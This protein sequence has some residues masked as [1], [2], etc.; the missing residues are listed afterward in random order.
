MSYIKCPKSFMSRKKMPF[1]CP[2]PCPFQI[3][4]GTLAGNL[5]SS[6]TSGQLPETTVH[7]STGHAIGEGL[8]TATNLLF[9]Q[10]STDAAPQTEQ[11]VS[12]S[13]PLHLMVTETVRQ[14][15]LA[16]KFVDM[17][18]LTDKDI[19]GHMTMVVNTSDDQPSLQLV[20]KSAQTK[21]LSIDEWTSKFNI[22]ISVLC[23]VE[24]NKEAFP[25]LLKYLSLVRNLANKHADWRYYDRNF[26]LLMANPACS[27]RWDECQLELWHEAL[28]RRASSTAHA[29][30]PNISHRFARG[31][32]CSG[33]RYLHKC[34]VCGAKHASTACPVLGFAG[35]PNSDTQTFRP[36]NFRFRGPRYGPRQNFHNF[37]PRGYMRGNRWRFGQ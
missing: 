13:V 4:A 25:G 11:F 33:C 9:A 8:V 22:F 37:Q 15:I 23:S 16:N 35:N 17:A 32:H 1:F 36:Q 34:G 26:R 18:T 28:T 20:K 5:T 6:S 27:L 7:A 29:Q 10:G 12:Q 21:T 19:D 30:T 14:K 31:E 2:A 24:Q 3:L